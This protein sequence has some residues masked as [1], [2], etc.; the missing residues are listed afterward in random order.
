[1]TVIGA[2]AFAVGQTAAPAAV[3]VSLSAARGM[4]EL[5][6]GLAVLAQLVG[7]TPRPVRA[8]V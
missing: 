7:E 1:V 5:E 3:R 8:I 2:D 4:D 6:R